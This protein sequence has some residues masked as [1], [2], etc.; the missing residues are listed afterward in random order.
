MILCIDLLRERPRLRD[1]QLQGVVNLEDE[2][3]ARSSQGSLEVE[4]FPSTAL[5]VNNNI[6]FS[7][8]GFM[9]TITQLFEDPATKLGWIDFSFNDLRTIDNVRIC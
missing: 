6:L 9:S 7:W 5:K 8:D 2:L 1:Q 4:K 3:S